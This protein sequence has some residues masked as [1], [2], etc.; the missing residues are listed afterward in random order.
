MDA[1]IIKM[2]N[3]KSKIKQNGYTLIEVIIAAVIFAIL[4]T[5]TMVTFGSNSKLQS[6]SEIIQTA[7]NNAKYIVESISR[8]IRLSD[9]VILSQCTES[10]NITQC[11]EIDINEDNDSIGYRFVQETDAIGQIEYIDQDI[12]NYVKL[13]SQD[14]V[15]NNMYFIDQGS[16]IGIHMEFEIDTSKVSEQFKQ[17]IDTSVTTR[18][19][20]N[21]YDKFT[22]QIQ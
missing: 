1:T 14:I 11:K 18:N 19:Y 15:I 4:I 7:S 8:D 17:T 16:Q 6:R 22:P 12:P 13:N 2:N 21:F 10:E 9:E 5:V 20:P 3:Q